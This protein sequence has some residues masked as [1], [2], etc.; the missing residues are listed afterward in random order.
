MRK[1]RY[2]WRAVNKKEDPIH[3]ECLRVVM[4]NP[5]EDEWARDNKEKTPS[6][7][8]FLIYHYLSYARK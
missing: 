2:Y 5:E 3:T 1:P 7:Q 6:N 8:T 4:E